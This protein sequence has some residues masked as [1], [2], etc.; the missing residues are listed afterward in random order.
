MSRHG[1]CFDNGQ[2]GRC[3]EEC[4]IFQHGDCES[5]HSVVEYALQHWTEEEIKEELESRIEEVKLFILRGQGK[6]NLELLC[7]AYGYQ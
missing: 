1:L 2:S 4:E 6:T 7:E 3:N 5:G